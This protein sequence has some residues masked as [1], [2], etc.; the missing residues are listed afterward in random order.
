MSKITILVPTNLIKTAPNISIIRKTILDLEK[1]VGLEDAKLI[2]GM[3]CKGKGTPRFEEYL[4]NIKR[5][6]PQH[7][8]MI[9]DKSNIYH[10]FSKL[11]NACD[12]EYCLLLEHDW[13]FNIPIDFNAIVNVMDKYDYVHNVRFNKRKNIVACTD[14]IL[15]KDDSITELPLTKTTSWSNNPKVMRMSHWTYCDIRLDSSKF[16]KG[17]IEQ[18]LYFEY[19]EDIKS[20]GFDTASKIWGSYLYGDINNAAVVSHLDGRGSN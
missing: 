13:V 6:F 11:F 5:E 2:I 16:N 4:A 7:E 8:I 20:M 15:V 18:A 19:N 1:H 17:N 9:S 10:N 14:S 3:D 12:T